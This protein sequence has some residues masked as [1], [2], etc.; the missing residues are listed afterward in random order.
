M[1]PP[2]ASFRK[3]S[4]DFSRDTNTVCWVSRFLG[5][6]EI[7]DSAADAGICYFTV[8]ESM[9]MNVG[10]HFFLRCLAIASRF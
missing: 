8:S 1:G 9:I 2:V 3:V 10:S 6:R 5:R 7:Q 4:I